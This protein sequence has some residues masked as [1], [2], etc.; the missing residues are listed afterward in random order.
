MG[1]TAKWVIFYFFTF[2]GATTYNTSNESGSRDWIAHECIDWSGLYTNELKDP[3]D[4]PLQLIW[5]EKSDI[6]VAGMLGFY[7][8]TK[9][10]H[11]FGPEITRLINLA[12]GKPV[13]LDELHDPVVKD[14]LSQMLARNLDKR[15]YVEQALKHPYLLYR[16]EQIQFLK[17]MGNE[18][19]SPDF[20]DVSSLLDDCH[21]SKHRSPLL[22][23]NWKSVIDSGDLE[24][25]CKGGRKSSGYKGKRYTHCLRL[26]RNVLEH[27]GDKLRRLVDKGQ[28]TSLGEYFLDR[29]PNLPLVVHQIIRK[30][31]DWKKRPALKEFFPEINRRAVSNEDMDED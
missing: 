31:P 22:E 9:G 26:I 23:P 30:Y 10:K 13:S 16:K 19:K 2:T 29:F 15:P 20:C 6:Q 1:I 5:K 25:L 11:P 24:T 17:A 8:L 18:P 21:P 27:P 12:N 3:S 28:A 4:E 14:L 7:I